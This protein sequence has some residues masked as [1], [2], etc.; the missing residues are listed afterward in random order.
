MQEIGVEGREMRPVGPEPASRPDEWTTAALAHLSILLTLILGPAGGVGALIGP[1]VALAMYFGYRQRSRFV[2]FHAMQSFVY[3][4]TAVLAYL[5]LGAIVSV[6]MTLAWSISG[7]LAAVLVGLLLMPFAFVLTLLSVLVLVA[8]P[9]AAL[10]Y[11]IYAAYQVYQGRDYRY[12]W[13]GAWLEKEMMW[14]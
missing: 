11:G 5:M 14:R 7:A 3:Q 10:A 2:A 9:V 1:A 12:P 13:I 6:W 4:V 8:A